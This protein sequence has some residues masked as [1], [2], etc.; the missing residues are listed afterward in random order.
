LS[1]VEPR[2]RRNLD[3]MT[4]RR[5]SIELHTLAAVLAER[6]EPEQ[7]REVLV[8]ALDQRSQDG[9]EEHDRYVLGRIAE[10]HAFLDTA[11][12]LYRVIKPT[13][14]MFDVSSYRL[15]QKRLA[16]I[17]T[18]P[19][20]GGAPAATTTK[21]ARSRYG[22]TQS[23]PISSVAQLPAENVAE[24]DANAAASSAGLTEQIGSAP[25]GGSSSVTRIDHGFACDD[26]RPAEKRVPGVIDSFQ[27]GV[28][29]LES[30]DVS[31][32]T[33]LPSQNAHCG[34]GAVAPPGPTARS[35][36]S[37]LGRV[38]AIVAR[39]QMTFHIE[40]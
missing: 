20:A 39:T 17:G 4:N 27:L 33:A 22:E 12:A 31:E 35:H 24:P 40:P 14:E 15:A 6:D 25:A 7:A 36:G 9:L 1:P 18:G 10:S 8:E 26:S 5:E 13:K 28:N 38:C 16:R 2:Q 34:S 21:S 3:R 11:R 32:A 37:P 29:V 30:T 23:R 19:T